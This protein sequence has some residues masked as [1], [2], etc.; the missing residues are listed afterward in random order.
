MQLKQFVSCS[1]SKLPVYLTARASQFHLSPFS[2]K[3]IYSGYLSFF[4][5]GILVN[6]SGNFI[7]KVKGFVFIFSENSSFRFLCGK[8]YAGSKKYTIARVIIIIIKTNLKMYLKPLCS[9]DGADNA[10]HLGGK[11]LL[12]CTWPCHLLCESETN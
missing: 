3:S 8:K 10:S 6:V 11:L 4:A 2:C 12:V 7:T 5:F 9:L 1:Y